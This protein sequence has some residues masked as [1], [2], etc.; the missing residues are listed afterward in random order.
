MMGSRFFISYNSTVVEGVELFL[1]TVVKLELVE[2][3][4]ITSH[5]TL[6]IVLL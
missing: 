3:Y 1:I 2:N 4:C 6:I 5:S